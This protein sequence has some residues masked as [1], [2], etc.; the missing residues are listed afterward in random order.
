MIATRSKGFPARARAPLGAVFALSAAL[1]CAA[2]PA[3]SSGQQ[4]GPPAS[5]PN[6][7]QP[8]PAGQIAEG[9][10]LVARFLDGLGGAAVV[11]R[12]VSLRLEGEFVT[13]GGSATYTATTWLLFPNRYRQVLVTPSGE[14]ETVVSPEAS[15]V[16][17]SGVTV[18]LAEAQRFDIERTLLRNPVALAK[19][20]NAEGFLATGVG[21][22]EI[23]GR[24]VDLLRLDIGGEVTTLALDRDS[25][26]LRRATYRSINAA[27]VPGPEITLSF[28]DHRVVNGLS[29]PF[30]FSAVANGI[31]TYRA[32]LK[33][34]VIDG[35]VDEAVFRP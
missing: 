35:P 17:A 8:V 25:G 4:G 21:V 20:R 18:P 6:R 31:P 16:R 11:D 3:P 27:G 7:S 28:M 32:S 19:T 33:S 22:S 24:A 2:R 13:G 12:I 14:I 15:F 10:R 30:E 29:Y 26:V 23:E 1:G 5:F 9:R 34:V